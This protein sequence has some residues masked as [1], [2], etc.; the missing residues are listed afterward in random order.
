MGEEVDMSNAKSTNHEIPSETEKDNADSTN[1]D[2]SVRGETSG[3]YY[4]RGVHSSI[5]TNTR[6]SL[7]L[8]L[9]LSVKLRKQVRPRKQRCGFSMHFSFQ[10]FKDV[11]CL[12]VYFN[13][14]VDF[15]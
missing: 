5:G 7:T 6:L 10:H 8:R 12:F 14:T 13:Y 1:Q 15:H 4:C 11:I 9:T 3:T 2:E